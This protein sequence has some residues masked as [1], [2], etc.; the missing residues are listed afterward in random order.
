MIYLSN[1]R[2]ILSQPDFQPEINNHQDVIDQGIKSVYVIYPPEW[3]PVQ[4][5]IYEGEEENQIKPM[6]NPIETYKKVSK[7]M[8]LGT[9]KIY[10]P[11]VIQLFSPKN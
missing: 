4:Y 10:K 1:L 7:Y 2:T 11:F 9:S 6:V 8:Y 3:I 5:G